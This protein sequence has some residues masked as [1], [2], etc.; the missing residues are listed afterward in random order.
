VLDAVTAAAGGAAR[1]VRA[2]LESVD[3]NP[4]LP[5]LPAGNYPA[6]VRIIAVIALIA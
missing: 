3:T 6:A 4:T 1:K 5:C 2:A